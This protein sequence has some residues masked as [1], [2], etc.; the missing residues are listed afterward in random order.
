MDVLAGDPR[1]GGRRV[2]ELIR[3]MSALHAHGT[4]LG[5]VR[6]SDV[7]VQVSGRVGLS[8]LHPL[9]TMSTFEDEDWPFIAPEVAQGGVWD[10]TADVF[11]LGAW[12]KLTGI[13]GDAEQAISHLAHKRPK[14]A[15]ELLQIA[16]PCAIAIEG[17]AVDRL[18][19]FARERA[20]LIKE[21]SGQTRLALLSRSGNS[22]RA[23]Q[24]RREHAWSEVGGVGAAILALDPGNVHGRRI[25]ADVAFRRAQQAE[26]RA[27]LN[28]LEEALETLKRYDDG[29]YAAYIR[30][31][32]SAFILSDPTGATVTLFQNQPVDSTLSPK[33]WGVPL[34]TPIENVLLP[35][36]SWEARIERHGFEPCVYPFWVARGETWD[37]TPPDAQQ[38][39]PIAMPPEGLV[40]DGEA[41]VPAGWTRLGGDRDAP[42][43]GPANWLW[44]E[45]FVILQYP[46]THAMYLEFLNDLAHHRRID[47]AQRAAPMLHQ[48]GKLSP[49]YVKG[50]A[51]SFDLPSRAADFAVH[52][53][54][55]V[56]GVDRRSVEQFALWYSVQTGFRWRL[57]T[58]AQWEK[59]ARGVDARAY[60][61]GNRFDGSR[62][63][64]R[65]RSRGGPP[66]VMDLQRDCSP[67]GVYGLA[68]GVR[69]WTCS[70]WN[71]TGPKSVDGFAA[72]GDAT[73]DDVHVTRG[74][75]FMDGP[76]LAR[77]AARIRIDPDARH[78]DLG[79]RLVRD[80]PNASTSSVPSIRREHAPPKP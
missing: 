50:F 4:V 68:G 76:L 46:V 67:Y 11:S 24:E 54:Q 64:T 48:H 49:I 63:W 12:M 59:A 15:L 29:T 77:C 32:G 65:G 34:R 1:S 72:P 31:E 45:D 58:E 43:S 47:E 17:T 57:P 26:R 8:R 56:M 61:W 27:D 28:A 42:G 5:A 22:E 2:I 13:L 71:D 51:N 75:S 30:G 9:P 39:E 69:E 7:V 21:L 52:G 18:L 40:Q 70:A 60:P 79:F 23:L 80:L 44:V 33:R 6:P 73:P 10:A 35:P 38:P 66:R 41:F 16:E 25:T 20:E 55:P 14:D 62:C 3:I 78:A 19:Q 36:G 53:D 74:S 37:P